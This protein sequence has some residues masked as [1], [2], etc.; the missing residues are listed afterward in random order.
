MTESFFFLFLLRFLTL[1]DH[2]GA[3]ID[4]RQAAVVIISHLD[5]LAKSHLPPTNCSI[6]VRLRLWLRNSLAKFQNLFIYRRILNNVRHHK[7]SH[8]ARYS[9]QTK[10]T[11][12]PSI[13]R[14]IHRFLVRPQLVCN[15]I[16]M[17][18]SNRPVKPSRSR[19]LRVLKSN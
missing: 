8:S 2:E 3:S 10:I 11:D 12:S 16:W 4:L 9:R 6:N 18:C 7:F 15:V 1:P 17:R 14:T 5:R 13:H 19:V